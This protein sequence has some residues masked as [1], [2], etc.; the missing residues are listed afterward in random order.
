MIVLSGG[1]SALFFILKVVFKFNYLSDLLGGAWNTVDRIN[2]PFGLMMVFIFIL[3]A[4]QLIKKHLSVGRAIFYF[5]VALLA[6]TCLV[7]LSFNIL[8]WVL[9]I[10]LIFLLILGA[11]FLNEARIWW[12][13]SLFVILILTVVFI[14]FGSPK[15]LQSSVPAEISLSLQ[16]SW[17][18][19]V[20]TSLD[21][22]KNFLLGSGL[23][24]F[25]MDFSQ[26]RPETFNYDQTAWSLRFGQP[27]NTF[28]AF[29]SE[30][31][32]VSTLF[33]LFF[34]VYALGHIT[35]SWFKNKTISFSE[36]DSTMANLRLDVFLVGLTWI[37]MTIGMFFSFF[38]PVAWVMWWFLLGLLVVGLSYFNENYLEV[39]TWEMQDTPQ[40]SLAF[41]FVSI[42][43]IAVVIMTGIWG[44]KL[45]LSEIIY[46]QALKS[47]DLAGAESKLIKAIEQRPGS[48]IYYAGLAQVYLMQATSLTSQ[49]NPDVNKI[50][51]LVAQAVNS[52]R[53]STELSPRSV[54][55]WENLANM[56]ENAALIV[57][58]SRQWALNSWEEA[59][60]LEPT[61]PVLLWRLGN[62]YAY[63]QEWDSAIEN[64]QKAVNLKTDY[65]TA[66]VDMA[67]VYE[68][69]NETEE[70]IKIYEKVLTINQ[71]N[72]D[73]LYNYGRLLYNRNQGDDRDMSEQLWLAVISQNPKY[74]NTLY[75]LGL[76]Y[77]SWGQPSKAVNYYYKVKELN[78]GNKDIVNKINSLFEE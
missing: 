29:L 72:I 56:Y 20:D 47:T 1:L 77:E 18:V 70:A 74:S 55:L 2:S 15:S 13:S 67:S 24:T 22:I 9:L 57:P 52:A 60:K 39:K 31:G 71:N 44:S 68:Q 8:W 10:G 53:R 50:S 3:S 26:F 40:Y 28:L 75:S 23:G 62:N 27:Y 46:S 41:S 45:Y 61:N 51:T 63:L 73:L 76:L 43:V 48:D 65:V 33:F 17:S 7:L 35:S 12:L 5:F 6:F 21:K 49:E 25:G 19:S 34:V 32:V 38:G 36:D 11:R 42:V 16:T 58:D 14:V 69:K 66:Y 64:Y 4:G 78:P 37:L 59:S 30:S 54:S